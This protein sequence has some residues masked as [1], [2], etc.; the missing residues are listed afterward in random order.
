[1]WQSPR[2][3]LFIPF[4]VMLSG[5]RA[6]ERSCAYRRHH[7]SLGWPDRPTM[8]A[9][10]AKPRARPRPLTLEV[11]FEAE[12]GGWEILGRAY[13]RLLPLLVRSAS[14]KS[15]KPENEGRH[16]SP[17]PESRSSARAAAGGDLRPGLFRPTGRAPHH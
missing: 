14:S 17:A 6:V 7:R 13:Q 15:Q 9:T 10:M 12:R 5:A 4:H 11:R 1:M 8:G 3:A 2:W 16:E